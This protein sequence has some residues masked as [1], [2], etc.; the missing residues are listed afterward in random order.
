MSVTATLDMGLKAV[1]TLAASLDLASNP[2]I[3]HELAVGRLTLNANSTPVASQVWSDTVALDTGAATIDLS[4]LSRGSAL[5]AL[6]LTGLKVQGFIIQSKAANT[7][8]VGIDV[9]A[10]NGYNLFGASDGRAVLSPGGAIMLY[11]PED[12]PDVASG[13]KTIDLSSSDADAQ[14]DVVILAG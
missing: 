12:L 5:S 3:T 4:S 9:G 11:A 2:N 8:T 10:S 1:E 14:V 7:D 13:A 6:D